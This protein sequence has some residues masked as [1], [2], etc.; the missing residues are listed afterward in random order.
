MAEDPNR[1][2]VR[3]LIEACPT[4]SPD[5]L[6]VD[7]EDGPY[8]WVGSLARHLVD[9]L[10]RGETC[11]IAAVLAVAERLLATDD[12]DVCTLVQVGLFEDLQNIAGGRHKEGLSI[13]QEDFEP[14]LGPLSVAAWQAVNSFWGGSTTPDA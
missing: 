8:I 1:G 14:F 9:K 13:R 3:A 2:A 7:D 6:M 12:H 10:S 5:S 11:E 4:A